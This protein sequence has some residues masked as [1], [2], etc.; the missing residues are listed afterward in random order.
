MQAS[1]KIFRKQAKSLSVKVCGCKVSMRLKKPSDSGVNGLG[2]DV[3]SVGGRGSMWSTEMDKEPT[4]NLKTSSGL[5][6]STEAERAGSA[7][8][9]RFR[10]SYIHLTE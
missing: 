3:A 10:G 7:V 5:D 1:A 2:L 9:D 8:M 4:A 6:S